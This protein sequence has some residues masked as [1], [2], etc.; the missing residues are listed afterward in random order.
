MQMHPTNTHPTNTH[1]M[2]TRSK[3]EIVKTPPNLYLYIG[4]GVLPM[5]SLFG[6]AIYY[7]VT[8]IGYNSV[9]AFI[10]LFC[11]SYIYGSIMKEIN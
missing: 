1:H 7:L 11:G 4:L 6:I 2:I 5:Y 8:N 3:R 9:P 10:Y